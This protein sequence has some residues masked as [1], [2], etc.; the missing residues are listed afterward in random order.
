MP[1]V[2][3]S[4]SYARKKYL[5]EA[6]NKSGKRAIRCDSKK[7]DKQGETKSKMRQAAISIAVGRIM[8]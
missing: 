6:R 4:F 8:Q 1:V 3:K 7:T 5:S 2:P